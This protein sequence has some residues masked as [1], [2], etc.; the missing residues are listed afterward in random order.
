MKIVLRERLCSIDC[1]HSLA[2]P[3]CLDK[4]GCLGYS[5]LTSLP[6][7]QMTMSPVLQGLKQTMFI[8]T[9][10]KLEHAQEST[11]GAAFLT[12]TLPEQNVKFE[13]W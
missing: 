10:L 13:I 7:V 5:L 6:E 2:L 9:L 4:K 8:L 1:K 11:I 3:S 12:K